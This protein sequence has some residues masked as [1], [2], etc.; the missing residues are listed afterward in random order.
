MNNKNLLILSLWAYSSVV[1]WYYT[2]RYLQIDWKHFL[3]VR[4]K[5]VPAIFEMLTTNLEHIIVSE[6]KKFVYETKFF[7][8]EFLLEYVFFRL[9][10]ETSL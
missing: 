4:K 1:R 5:F 9:L 3:N 7:I 10:I 8:C 2:D 6:G